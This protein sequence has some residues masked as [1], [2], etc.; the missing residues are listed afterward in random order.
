MAVWDADLDK[1]LTR[2]RGIVCEQE[3]DKSRRRVHDAVYRRLCGSEFHKLLLAEL[4][5]ESCELVDLPWLY[6]I[7]ICTSDKGSLPRFCMNVLHTGVYC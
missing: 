1:T 7:L 3:L 4:K 6:G 2:S 5:L